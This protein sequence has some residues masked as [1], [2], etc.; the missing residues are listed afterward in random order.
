M[1]AVV[2]FRGPLFANPREAI[3]KGVLPGLKTMAAQIEATVLLNT[4]SVSR[5]LKR[6]VG[7]SIWPK[8][9]GLTVKSTLRA[10]RRTW[11]ERG[12]RRGI[13]IARGYYMWRKGKAKAKEIRKQALLAPGIAKELNG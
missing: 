13:K 10:K 12:T 7:S 6:S 5:E 11:S 2:R 3:R 9:G 1:A 4:P 8:G